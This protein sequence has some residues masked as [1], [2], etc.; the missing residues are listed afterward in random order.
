[1]TSVRVTHSIGDLAS[2]MAKIPP[3]AQRKLSATVKKNTA[4][5]EKVARRLARERAGP[6]GKNAFKRITSEMVGPLTGE[7]GWTGDASQIV[8]AG[9]RNGPPNTDLERSQDIVGPK[10]AADVSD[11]V[12]RLFW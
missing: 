5:G 4:Y 9:W 6:H 3:A 2:D 10:F 12:D 7:Y 11:V 8:G 1:M